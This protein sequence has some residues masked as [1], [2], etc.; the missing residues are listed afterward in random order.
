[1]RELG[2]DG[3]RGR[4]PGHG[5][6]DL[7]PFDSRHSQGESQWRRDLTS[8]LQGQVLGSNCHSGSSSGSN[9]AS[10]PSFGAAGGTAKPRALVEC[11]CGPRSLIAAKSLEFNFEKALRFTEASHPLGTARG[12]ER[13]ESDIKDLVSNGFQVHLWASVPC[14]PWTLYSIINSARLGRRFRAKLRAMRSKS[15][16][17]IKEFF[18]LAEMVES[19]GGTWSFEWPAYC[20]GWNL[21][22]LK[23]WPAKRSS[24]LARFD[25]CRYGLKSKKGRPIKKPW[26]IITSHRSLAANLDGNL[27][28]CPRGSHDPCGGANTSATENYSPQLARA[29]VK[30]ISEPHSKAMNAKLGGP[31][32]ATMPVRSESLSSSGLV[33]PAEPH[34]LPELHMH[35]HSHL[36]L[37]FASV[38][39]IPD[40]SGDSH[41]SKDACGSSGALGMVTRT[42]SP[43]SSE[44]HS[45]RGKKAIDEEVSDLRAAKVWRE[46]TVRELERGQA[47]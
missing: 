24:Y 31:F 7:E 10:P 29:A 47:Y 45:T 15:I 33:P 3:K 8:T 17:I 2:G 38:D 11:C 25:G 14:R 40:G 5:G 37:S 20:L 1:M 19:S 36:D 28:E 44:F 23:Q 16:Q 43:K 22:F 27:C 42:I 4:G 12:N 13:A 41:R 26:I 21:D 30:A 39:D 35:L 46:E 6:P 34:S 9:C 18:K 32:H